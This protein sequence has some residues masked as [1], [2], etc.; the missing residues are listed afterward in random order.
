MIPVEGG[1]K[2]REG[3][4]SRKGLVSRRVHVVA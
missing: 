4:L 3:I 1:L 2:Q